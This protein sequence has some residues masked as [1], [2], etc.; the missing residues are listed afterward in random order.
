MS[1]HQHIAVIAIV[2]GV[3]THGPAHAQT[4]APAPNAVYQIDLDTPD[5]HSSRWRLNDLTTI[6]A[7]KTRVKIKRLG[8]IG[9]YSPAFTIQILTAKSYVGLAIHEVGDR[10]S[11]SLESGTTTPLHTDVF[12]LSP[13][14]NETFEVEMEWKPDG[15][16]SI[17]ISTN[18]TDPA[19]GAERH[20][21]KMIG[22]PVRL[23]VAAGTGQ[24]VLDP[25][26]L[27]H[28]AP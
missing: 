10:L 22:E 2:A 7:L 27:G 20:E 6:N 21:A 8:P 11:A 17:A 26:Q 12:A 1:R 19:S 13:K 5:N 28:V 14:I 23:E 15:P 9:E 25:L 18:M 3:A 4:F 24:M 16:V